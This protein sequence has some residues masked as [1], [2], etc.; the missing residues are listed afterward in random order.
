MSLELK[1]VKRLIASTRRI[2]QVTGAL[3]KVSSARLVNDRKAME[4]SGRYTERLTGI[5]NEI[6]VTVP[7]FDNPLLAESRTD[8]L[9]SLLIAFG[10][11]RGLCGS[12]NTALT[13]ELE[14]FAGTRH[15]GNVQLVVVGRILNR[16]ARRLGLRIERFFNQ[17]S[18]HARATCIDAIT[19]MAIDSFTGDNFREVLVMYTKFSSGVVQ[20]PVVE[21]VLPAPFTPGECAGTFRAACFEPGPDRIIERLLPEFVRQA[22]DHAFLQSIASENAARQAAMTRASE[23]A[24]DILSDLT[25]SYSRLRQENITM[26][27][28]E[29]G[30]IAR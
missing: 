16:R 11:D 23:N 21:R 1:E 3:Q 26:E 9:S 8:K 28:I 19:T 24:A 25:Q 2:R 30:G 17:P 14:R 13:R 10:S 7:N 12:F 4:S 20:T 29:L 6:C 15:P 18:R 22:I 5:L 27:I